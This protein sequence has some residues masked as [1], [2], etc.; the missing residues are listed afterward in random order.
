M[1][2]LR[3]RNDGMV[4]VLVDGSEPVASWKPLTFARKFPK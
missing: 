1:M 3:M 2:P 4:E